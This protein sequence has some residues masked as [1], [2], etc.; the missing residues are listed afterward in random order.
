MGLTE[1][2]VSLPEDILKHHETCSS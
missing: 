2:L 1:E